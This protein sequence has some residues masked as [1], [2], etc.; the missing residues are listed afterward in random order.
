MRLFSH[1]ELKTVSLVLAV[2]LW[3]YTAG[4]VRVE[5]TIEITVTD[6]AVQGLPDDHQLTTITPREFKVRLSVP[7][8]RLSELSGDTIVPRLTLTPEGVRRR[9]QGFPITSA[10]LGLTSDIRIDAIEPENVREI[11]VSLDQ[12]AEADFDVEPPA[13]GGLPPGIEATAPQTDVT[14]VRLRAPAAELE[15]MRVAALRVRFRAV[16]LD[17]TDALLARPRQERVAL[18]PIEAPYKVLRTV[19][20]TF[21]VRPRPGVPKV[22]TVPVEVLGSRDLLRSMAVDIDQPRLALTLRGPENLLTALR[23][24][25]DLVAY[26]RLR[27]DLVPGEPHELPVGVLAPPWMAVE[28]ALV[29]VTLNPLRPATPESETRP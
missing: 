26:V 9:S 27:D 11:T 23:P 2:A 28:P 10:A 22:V 19:Y 4:Q 8:N 25:A 7:T 5:K 21:T 3:L 13:V 16:A 15:R 29:R 14:R 18:T 17:G 12:I 1:W 24:E 20:A 6:Q